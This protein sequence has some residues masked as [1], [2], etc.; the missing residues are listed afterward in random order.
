[1]S[2]L[3]PEK[4][5][6]KKFQFVSFKI[7]VVRKLLI[8]HFI[9]PYRDPSAFVNWISVRF[10][11]TGCMQQDK[12]KFFLSRV[13]CVGRPA[14][15]MCLASKWLVLI[16]MAAFIRN[17]LIFLQLKYKIQIKQKRT[18]DNTRNNIDQ[19]CLEGGL[20]HQKNTYFFNF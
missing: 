12:M 4:C 15:I 9:K 19:K 10:Y 8:A 2:T 6:D 11:E 13:C 5:G 14:L 16:L 1:M 3:L 20:Y 18:I 17:F 7:I